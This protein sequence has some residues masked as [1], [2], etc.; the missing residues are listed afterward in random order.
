MSSKYGG[1][2]KNKHNKKYTNIK[3]NKYGGHIIETSL[4][5]ALPQAE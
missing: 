2:T 1:H 3:T 4:N 5:G